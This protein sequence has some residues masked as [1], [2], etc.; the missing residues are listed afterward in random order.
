MTIISNAWSY[1]CMYQ[2]WYA[3][4]SWRYGN[5]WLIFD[6]LTPLSALK[7][8]YIWR[9][10]FISSLYRIVGCTHSTTKRLHDTVWIIVMWHHK[11]NLESTFSLTTIIIHVY[12]Y[13]R[14]NVNYTNSTI[15][16]YRSG[17]V[18]TSV[19][20]LII[21]FYKI[22]ILPYCIELLLYGPSNIS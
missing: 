22:Y 19:Q 3:A 8:F 5:D 18:K 9:S 1:N 10:Y 11:K 4:E 7:L 20:I 2:S 12:D 21:L 15:K 13:I 17:V 16:S 14:C 6:V